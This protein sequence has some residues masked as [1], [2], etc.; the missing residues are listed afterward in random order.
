MPRFARVERQD[1]H[2]REA[3]FLKSSTP[4]VA[5]PRCAAAGRNLGLGLEDLPDFPIDTRSVV[6]SGIDEFNPLGV[7]LVPGLR[8]QVRRLHDVFD[9]VA[10]IVSQRS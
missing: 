8:N 4:R 7:V 1:L 9:S 5:A 2:G 6:G 3:S 10:Q